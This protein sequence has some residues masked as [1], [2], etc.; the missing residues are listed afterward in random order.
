MLYT[1]FGFLAG[2]CALLLAPRLPS[3]PAL[4]VVTAVA[5]AAAWRFRSFV[6]IAFAAGFMLCR[7]DA[8]TRL[9]DRLDTAIEGQTLHVE[10]RVSSVPQAVAQGIRFRFQPLHAREPR[11]PATIELTWYEPPWIPLPAERLAL[12]LRLRRPRGFANP[13]GSDY[14]A[15]MLREGVGATGYVRN[16]ARRGRRPFDVLANPVLVARG[17]VAQ[18]IAEALGARAATG[19]V[20]GLAVGLQDALSPEQWRALARSGTS[21]LMAI[22]GLHI[23]M[24]AALVAWCAAAIQRVRQRRGALGTV[25]DASVRAGVVAAITYAALAGWSVPTQR[26]VLMIAVL[27]VALG[28]RRRTGAWDGLAL[29]AVAVLIADPMSAL[30]PGFWLSFGAVAAI[31]FAAAGYVA[32]QGVLAGYGRV[33]VAVTIGLVP[34]LIGSFGSVSLVSAAV[35]LIAIPLYTLLIVPAVLLATVLAIAVPAAGA[36][37][38]GGVGWLIE[39]TW[40]LIEAPAA[41]SWAIWSVAGLPLLVWCALAAA[42][43]AALAP[44]P[45][46]ARVAAC[47]VI[48]AAGAW[49]PA[50]LQPG[51]ARVAMLD[52]G[53]GL[54][55]VIETRGHV[56][57]YDTGPSFRSGSDAGLLAVAPYLRH[58]GMRVIDLLVVS[59]D[60]SDHAG[61]AASLMATFPVRARAASGQALGHDVDVIRCERGGRW[62]WDG[63]EF[64]WLHPGPVQARKDNDQSCVLHIR[65]GRHTAL[66]TGDIEGEGERELLAAA[67]PGSIDVLVVPHHGSR[68][69]SSASLVDATRPRWALISCG[70]R[71]R[72]R[73]P[74]DAVV[75]R[76]QQAGST[77]LLSWESGAV[78]FELWSDRD[79]AAPRLARDVHMRF[80]HQTQVAP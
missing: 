39:T 49:R 74:A 10:G 78:E 16:G 53:Q 31:V 12:E 9:D 38:L 4:L 8:G 45:V 42:T 70:Y 28:A 7:V 20:A 46:A 35:N 63:V 57:V 62:N 76:W 17:E 1:A 77:V 40:V 52:V 51:E 72:W 48:V 58:R 6:P 50:P 44:V 22:S 43:V 54:A 19:I 23:G 25:R 71:N 73:F 24:V 64:K 37:A 18:V 55:V 5:I 27:A 13:G 30:A 34:A 65:A 79:I 75:R 26:T 14:A 61:G 59:H 41:W 80:W 47:A 33:Q 21:H 36:A 11:L 15:R 60:D 68:S 56:L 32:K 66:L 2:T 29:A 69:S 3:A 67:P